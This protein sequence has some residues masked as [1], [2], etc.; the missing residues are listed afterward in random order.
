MSEPALTVLGPCSIRK[1]PPRRSEQALP[2]GSAWRSSTTTRRPRRFRSQAQASPEMP[3]PIIAAST[4]NARPPR[5]FHT[6]PGIS[7]TP[8]HQLLH[9]VNG[10]HS[11]SVVAGVVLGALA[12]HPAQEGRR[13]FQPRLGLHRPRK[14]RRHLLLRL[15]H[16]AAFWLVVAQE[17]LLHKP[18]APRLGTR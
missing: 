18:A 2:P 1:P 17:V 3:P 5:Y 11:M 14:R 16:R 15:D 4:V 7:E 9:I 13:P 12:D 8:L 6:R 10:H